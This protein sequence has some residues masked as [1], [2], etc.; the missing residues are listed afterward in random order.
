M[1]NA[2]FPEVRICQ[3]LTPPY[4][5]TCVIFRCVSKI[6]ASIH[7]NSATFV[8]RH[9][10]KSAGIPLRYGESADGSGARIS[11]LPTYEGVFGAATAQPLQQPGVSQNRWLYRRALPRPTKTLFSKTSN[12]SQHG[13]LPGPIVP[14]LYQGGPTRWH[15][16]GSRWN[17]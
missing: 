13:I 2:D 11:G 17:A 5:M 6:T 8:F 9:P 15:G 3:K 7:L 16:L 1:F 10:R 4:Y 12:G 14:T